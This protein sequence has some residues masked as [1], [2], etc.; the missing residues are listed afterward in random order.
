M[1][2]RRIKRHRK[3]QVRKLDLTKLLLDLGLLLHVKGNLEKGGDK[4]IETPTQ[5]GYVDHSKAGPISAPS[6]SM[7]F[8]TAGL[9]A[10]KDLESY[11][12]IKGHDVSHSEMISSQTKT[13]GR[14]LKSKTTGKSQRALST[15]KGQ[16]RQIFTRQ[17]PS[18]ECRSTKAGFG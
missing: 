10:A 3:R 18:F 17:N 6:P 13:S 5:S 12:A 16:S 14:S 4:D 9:D 8:P 7:G 15:Q 1:P 11:I 2:E